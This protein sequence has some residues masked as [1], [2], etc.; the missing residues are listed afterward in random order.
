MKTLWDLDEAQNCAQILSTRE[1][2]FVMVKALDIL[3]TDYSFLLS[4]RAMK[5]PFLDLHS[6]KLVT[7][8]EVKLWS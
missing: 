1:Y 7:F 5:V 8:L 3:H 6:E 4:T 2:A